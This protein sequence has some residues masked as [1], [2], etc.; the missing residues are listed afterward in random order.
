MPCNLYSKYTTTKWILGLRKRKEERVRLCCCFYFHG[1][2]VLVIYLSI[3]CFHKPLNSAGVRKVRDHDICL[4]ESFWW[5]LVNTQN[6]TMLLISENILQLT[7]SV[8]QR[9]RESIA[10]FFFQRNITPFNVCHSIFLVG[11][12]MASLTPIKTSWRTISLFVFHVHVLQQF[13]RK[14]WCYIF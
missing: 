7:T 6:K 2:F 9:L 8:P 11:S 3:F 5:I 12:G 13:H 14:N 1:F 10:I 4:V